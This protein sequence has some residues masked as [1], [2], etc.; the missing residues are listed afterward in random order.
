MRLRPFKR[1]FFQLRGSK[2]ASSSKIRPTAT[3]GD[4]EKTHLRPFERNFF[5]AP[6]TKGVPAPKIRPTAG[7][8]RSDCRQG[9]SPLRG[10][11]L[12]PR[13]ASLTASSLR[14]LILLW[15][16]G[17]PPFLTNKTWMIASEEENW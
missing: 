11:P 16:A 8:L 7:S 12:V 1:D 10:A 3:M 2:G 17:A 9:S 5:R 6:M 14:L 13:S 4:L 15:G